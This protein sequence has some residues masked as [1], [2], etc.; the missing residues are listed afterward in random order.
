MKK[1]VGVVCLFLMIG[2]LISCSSGLTEK[3]DIINLFSKNETLFIEAVQTKN[4]ERVENIRGIQSVTVSEYPD[5][6]DF[7]C[8]GYGMGSQTGYYGFF[9]SPDDNVTAVDVAGPR[10]ELVEDGN[11]Y[12]W[13]EKNG[14]NIYYVEQIGDHF[15]YYE[16]HF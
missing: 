13:E 2:T 9:Y 6:I 11:G 3:E 1:I 14:D 15:F 8:G 10:D 16:A 5:Y 12:R 7:S 4:F